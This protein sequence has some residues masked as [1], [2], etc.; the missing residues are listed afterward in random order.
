MPTARTML[1]ALMCASLLALAGAQAA[2]ATDYCVN[3]A[4]C[5]GGINEG[6]SANS[7]Q[8]ALEEAEN[9]ST[10]VAPTAC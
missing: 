5:A 4:S 9:T 2:G 10:P 6:T 7:V 1:A 3:E 8:I